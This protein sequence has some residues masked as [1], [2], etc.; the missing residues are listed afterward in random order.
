MTKNTLVTALNIIGEPLEICSCQP[1]TGWHRDG[2]CK[3]DLADEGKHIVCCIMSE[4]FL[5]YSKA[6]GNDLTTS[7]PRFGFN[8]LK[9]GDHWCLCALR[10]KQAYEDG[11]APLV[12]IKSTALEALEIINKEF[13]LKHAYLD[14]KK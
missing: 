6:Q 14:N 4:S 1:M 11:M 5:R 3:T 13:L 7:I 2:F 12:D 8:G 10:W 9:P